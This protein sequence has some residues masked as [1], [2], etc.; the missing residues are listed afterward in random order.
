MQKYT[1]ISILEF[2]QKDGRVRFDERVRNDI[3]FIK[4]F[5]TNQWTRF[6]KLS[7]ISPDVER[8]AVLQR[9]FFIKNHIF[10]CFSI[11]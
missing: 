9:K 5:S 1:H 11:Y 4:N 3:D 8:D 7:G 6:L 2:L 10:N